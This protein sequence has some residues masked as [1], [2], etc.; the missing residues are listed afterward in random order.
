MNQ[1]IKSNKESCQVFIS[2]STIDK[3]FAIKIKNKLETDEILT[4]FD[5]KDL[6]I[7]DI[8]SDEISNGITKSSY[9]LIIISENKK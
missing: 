3:P 7:G 6:D 8:L 9:F 1:F 2:H 4:W 5:N